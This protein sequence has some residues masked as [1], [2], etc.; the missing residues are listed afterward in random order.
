[1]YGLWTH[2]LADADPQRSLDLQTDSGPLVDENLRMRIV[3]LDE[4]IIF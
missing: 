3:F 1:M 4:C 2:S